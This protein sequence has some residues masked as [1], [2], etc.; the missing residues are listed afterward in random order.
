[1]RAA[2][3]AYDLVITDDIDILK[4]KLRLWKVTKESKG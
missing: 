1:M 2:I 4:Y 3:Y